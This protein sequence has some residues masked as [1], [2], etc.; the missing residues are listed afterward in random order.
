[1]RLLDSRRP[2]DFT[3][4]LGLLTRHPTPEARVRG[5][6]ER[7]LREVET[8]GDA[9][10]I[11]IN[12]RFSKKKISRTTLRVK[13]KFRAPPPAVRAA[14][15]A[16]EANIGDFAKATRPTDWSHRNRQG[17]RVGESFPA[18]GRVGVYVPGGTA[19]LVS[20]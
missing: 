17:A 11:R 8:G 10:L 1:M 14:L 7:I 16:A 5:A 18:L 19:P 2:K 20:T 4:V 9:A 3:R 6:V 13:G 12:N 15:A